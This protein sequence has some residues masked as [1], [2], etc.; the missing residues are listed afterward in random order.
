MIASADP[1]AGTFVLRGKTIGTA[2][3][4]LRIVGGTRA[5]LT[6]YRRVEVHGLIAKDGRHVEATVIVFDR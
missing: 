5:D 1:A 4:D 6:P 3:G 2:R